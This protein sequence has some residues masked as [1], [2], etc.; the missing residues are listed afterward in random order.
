[1]AYQHVHVSE[2]PDSPVVECTIASGLMV[3]RAGLYGSPKEPPATAA[4]R[5]S[6]RVACGVPDNK[7]AHIEPDLIRGVMHRYGLPLIASGLPIFTTAPDDTYWAV[8]GNYAALPS[9][10]QRWDR[11][12]AKKPLP[13]HCVC[14]RKVAGAL[15]WDDPLAPW[16]PYSGEPVTPAIV[17]AYFRARPGA[18]TTVAH[19]PVPQHAIRV[20]RGTVVEY[21]TVVEPQAGVFRVVPGKTVKQKYT[22]PTAAFPCSSPVY[23]PVAKTTLVYCPSGLYRTWVHAVGAGISV[24]SA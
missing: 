19:V 24:V 4:E 6:L 11:A 17:A 3:A 10:F 2:V 12:F 1:M 14:V 16:G 20:V 23:D 7:G 15:I 8:Q 18:R 13:G 21:P 22:G 9:H 5:E